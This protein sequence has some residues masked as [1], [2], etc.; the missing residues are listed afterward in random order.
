MQAMTDHSTRFIFEEADIRG[1]WVSLE[2]SYAAVLGVHDYPPAVANLLGEFIVASTLL[3]STI[4]FNGSLSLQVSPNC[5]TGLVMAQCNSS[6]EVRAIAR[7]FEHGDGSGLVEALRD[8]QLAITIEPGQGPR[9]QGVVAF[10]NT[11]LAQALAQYFAQSEQLATQLWLAAD[12]KRC[13]GLLLQQLPEQVCTSAQQRSRQW[14]HAAQLAATLTAT[15]L[16]ELSADELLYR[17]YHQDQI[18]RAHV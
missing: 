1:E 18:G 13:A 4:K 17:L 7:G 14:E 16:L 11:D 12:G 15:E 8:G 6:R 10:T 2:Q 3:S 5:G 9:Y